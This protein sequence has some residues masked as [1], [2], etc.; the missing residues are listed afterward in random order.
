MLSNHA[1]AK[2]LLELHGALTSASGQIAIS[3]AHRDFAA[4]AIENVGPITDA[5]VRGAKARYPVATLTTGAVATVVPGEIT[6][7]TRA[8]WARVAVA[9]FQSVVA[10]DDGDAISDLICDLLHLADETGQ[11]GKVVLSRAEMHYEAEVDE[12]KR[13]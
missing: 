13:E 12:E 10:T 3:E 8:A 5:L 11:C 6:N 2:R 9:E 1:L 4:L 7:A